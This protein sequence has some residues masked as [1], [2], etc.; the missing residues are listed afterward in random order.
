MAE[1]VVS[2]SQAAMTVLSSL[3]RLVSPG[4]I[5]LLTFAGAAET[6]ES[7][8][9]KDTLAV[10]QKRLNEEKAVLIDVR[11]KKEW[12]AGHLEQAS[13]LPLSELGRKLRDPKYVAALKKKLPADK[14]IYLH[15][16]A[17]GRCVLAAEALREELG[18]DYD[19]RALKPGYEEL[20][21]AGFEPAPE[22]QP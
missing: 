6:A 1:S 12:E 22:E 21:K 19:F 13:L 18:P 11:E 3:A 16:K 10:V 2:L 17:G 20:T 5:A 14:P 4:V 7:P 15:C 8:H 9:T